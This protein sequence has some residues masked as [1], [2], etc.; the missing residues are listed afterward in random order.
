M[1]NLAKCLNRALTGIC[2]EGEKNPA[3]NKVICC[4]MKYTCVSLCHCVRSCCRRF[5][6]CHCFL[7]S[8]LSTLSLCVV[9]F[10]SFFPLHF[11]FSLQLLYVLLLNIPP[12]VFP[13]I[14]SL[15]AHTPQPLREEYLVIIIIHIFCHTTLPPHHP[16]SLC[17]P[18]FSLCLPYTHTQH[19]KSSQ[20]NT[21]VTGTHTH[22]EQHRH[23]HIHTGTT[24]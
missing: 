8:S 19:T 13:P 22:T 10:L 1:N 20:E 12:C 11:F 14:S 9:P 18:L 15:S 3:E 4:Y 7:S 24:T 2:I 6:Y 16:P 23:T 5:E 17:N 21:A